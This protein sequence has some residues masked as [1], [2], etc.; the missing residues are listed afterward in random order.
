MIG[1]VI[2]WVFAIIADF[3]ARIGFDSGQG[4]IWMK[5]MNKMVTS[6]RNDERQGNVDLCLG[7]SCL[8]HSFWLVMFGFD[9]GPSLFGPV[10]S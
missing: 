9:T 10:M 6:S 1:L 5:R 2:I 4:T 3:D 7:S 8:S